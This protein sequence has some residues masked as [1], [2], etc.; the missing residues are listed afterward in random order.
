VKTRPRELPVNA[1]L[2]LPNDARGRPPVE[3]D[4]S[5][6]ISLDTSA[7]DQLERESVPDRRAFV[8]GL[9]TLGLVRVTG[10][11]VG[12]SLSIVGEHRLRRLTLLKDL[13][14][15][16]NPA[17]P[18]NQLLGD[19][20][21][22]YDRGD[23]TFSIGDEGCWIALQNPA[24]V[25]DDMALESHG[26]H[27]DREDWFREMYREFRRAYAPIFKKNRHNRPRS[28]ATL[29]RYFIE[30]GPQYWDM[31]LI[32][33]YER[34][35]GHRPTHAEFE[36]FLTRVPASKLFWLAQIY[37][38]FRRS[39]AKKNRGRK[40]AGLNDLDSAIYLPFCDWFVTHDVQQRRAL[41]VINV[42][43]PR[44]TR[45]LSYSAMRAR[46]LGF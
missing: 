38:L 1:L 44:R 4:A 27:S 39:V 37:A 23:A 25:N 17:Q 46:L 43:N 21:Q 32:P 42:A 15:A 22:A 8:A 19:I 9:K 3:D 41:R 28:A 26:W 14:G 45:I 16:F 5:F 30:R 34:Q 13:T 20:A 36:R 10:L 24:A 40:D 31:L 35:T 6:V 11:N 2:F 7:I 33:I 18:P 29:I 12:E